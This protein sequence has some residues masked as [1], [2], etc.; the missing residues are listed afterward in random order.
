[1]SQANDSDVILAETAGFCWG[2]KRAMDIALTVAID[3]DGPVYTHGPLIH[4]PQVI[5]TLEGKE[6]YEAKDTQKLS[7]GDNV[8][9]RTHGVTPEVRN[10]LKAQKLSIADATCPLVAKVQG[11]IKK[12]ANRGYSTIVIGDTGHAEVIGLLGFAQGLG[13]VIASADEVKDLPPF[14]DVCVVAQTTCDT[15]R[16]EKVVAKIRERFPEAVVANTICDATG[17]R[18]GEVI[19]MAKDVEAIVVV[20]GKNSANTARLATIAKEAGVEV[21]LVETDDEI[22]KEKL[23]RFGK[24]GVTAGAST[25]AWMIERVVATIKSTR[26][27]KKSSWRSIGGGCC[28]TLRRL[29]RLY[30]SRRRFDDFG[31][32][33]ACPNLLQP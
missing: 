18:Q 33:I 3:N 12:Y 29:Q 4:N 31:Q 1:M 27:K 21:F 11:I 22:N 23:S 16:Y 14:D 26:H 28:G 13:H 17:D 7:A 15:T 10:T 19:R 6:V 2:V 24:I 25:P 20:G 5:E 32:R 30:R 9:I 8:I